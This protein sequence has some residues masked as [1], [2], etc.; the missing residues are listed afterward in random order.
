[1]ESNM[2]FKKLKQENAR[3]ERAIEFQDLLIKSLGKKC[4]FLQVENLQL[5]SMLK[6]HLDMAELL[7]QQEK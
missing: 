1:M 6:T 5:K 3:L 7:N 2:F 4:D